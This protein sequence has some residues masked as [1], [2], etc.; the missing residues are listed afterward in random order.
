M[1]NHEAWACVCLP[2]F[3]Q[4]WTKSYIS[5]ARKSH[6]VVEYLKNPGETPLR[7]PSKFTLSAFIPSEYTSIV[8]IRALFMEILDPPVVFFGLLYHW[9]QTAQPGPGGLSVG[10][11]SVSVQ[12]ANMSYYLI[13]VDETHV[14]W[15]LKA[16]WANMRPDDSHWYQSQRQARQPS[17][18]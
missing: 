5:S 14:D 17:P 3:L 13:A 12:R 2:F 7:S 11:L 4:L 9:Y 10:T 8:I 15:I 18:Y 16:P 1:R 6:E